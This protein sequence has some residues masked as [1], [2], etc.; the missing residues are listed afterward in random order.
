MT[1]NDFAYSGSELDALAGAKNYYRVLARRFRPYVGRNVLEVG[2]GVGTFAE[3]LLA[4]TPA[5]RLTLLEPAD[6]NYPLLERRFATIPCVRTV[7]GYLED[8]AGKEEFDSLVAVNVLEHVE[9]DAAFL[10]TAHSVL[11]AEGALLLFVPALP[12]IFGSLDRAFEHYRRYTRRTLASLLARSGF[13]VVDLRY[14]N[15]P[16]AFAWF[17]TGRVLR[18]QTIHPGEVRFY[19]RWMVPWISWLERYSGPPFGQSLVAIAKPSSSLVK[20]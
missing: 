14:T 7:H 16:G 5:S 19:D 6:N 8:L 15:L 10:H 11:K 17:V 12:L 4:E 9:H 18:R 2:A 1:A 3:Y 13:Q 20:D